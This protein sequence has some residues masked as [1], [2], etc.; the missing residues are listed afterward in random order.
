MPVPRMVWVTSLV[1]AVA[2]VAVGMVAERFEQPGRMVETVPSPVFVRLPAAGWQGGLA[3][4]DQHL[5]RPSG[6]GDVAQ[7]TGGHA[8]SVW[9]GLVIVMLVGAEWRR[10][11]RWRM[12][13]LAIAQVPAWALTGSIFVLEN[14]ADDPAYRALMRVAFT[15][16]AIATS[17]LLVG[18]L[19][20]VLRPARSRWRS[21]LSA[22][23]L[24]T[25]ATVLVVLNILAAFLRPPDD[26]SVFASLGAQRLIE[27]GRLPYGD[28][29]LTGTPGAAY[30]P[31]MYG[32]HA[33]V[34]R[35]IAAPLNPGATLQTTLGPLSTY[36]EPQYLGTKL[37][38][39]L[40]QLGAAGA[41]LAI[42]WT[43]DG[44]ALGYAL[45]ML[46]C[47]SAYV[48]GY[49]GS[50]EF[51]GGINYVSHIVPVTATLFAFVSLATPWLA[52]V[53]LGVAAGLGFYPAF[54][55]P[56][57]LAY[58][59]SKREGQWWRFAT[60]FAVVCGLTGVWVLTRSQPAPG[61]G[62]L[63]TIAR[64]TLGH[65]TDPAGYGSSPFGLWGQ[66]TGLLAWL[67]APLVGTSAL[68]SPFFG[69]FGGVIAVAA[70][71]ALRASVPELSMLT[72]VVAM[73]ANLWKIHATATYV[74]WFY[75]FLLI[76]LLAGGP[77]PNR[78]ELAAG[79]RLPVGED[80]NDDRHQA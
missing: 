40:S 50:T 65:H 67:I 14:G 41:L 9:L 49:G 22:P 62:L 13:M 77:D 48:L 30:G 66:Q 79:D 71:L 11:S 19:W 59:W 2:L 75:P 39:A 47:G 3:K 37:T 5:H 63:A 80:A 57:W 53:W 35:S 52:G 78:G 32:V 7:F 34:Q 25:G 55:F 6:A 64:D 58:Y 69:L 4:L 31:L 26:S 72:A 61:L 8:T 70:A 51:V 18:L 46:Y 60:G 36:R 74:T 29:I 15:V 43:L 24:A 21:P 33:L 68:T 10:G 76:G 12:A 28:P 20:R 45:V 23:A 1:V 38:L 54:M 73:G 16:V 27:T 42:G 17:A 56:V 44:P